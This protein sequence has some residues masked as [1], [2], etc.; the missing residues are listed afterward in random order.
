MENLGNDLFRIQPDNADGA[1]CRVVEQL[2]SHIFLMSAQ[3]SRTRQWQNGDGILVQI[4]GSSRYE[5]ATVTES[6]ATDIVVEFLAG[7]SGSCKHNAP[8]WVGYEYAKAA[9][10]YTSNLG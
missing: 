8:I 9:S 7:G 2:R 1:A 6:R 10:T 4:P 5:P 3:Q